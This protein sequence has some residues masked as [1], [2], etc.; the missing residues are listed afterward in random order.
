MPPPSKIDLLPP[1]VRAELDRRLIAHAFGNSVGL[2]EWLAEKGYEIGK[3]AV[4]LCGQAVL[5]SCHYDVLDW[6]EPD[7]IFDTASGRFERAE[8]GSRLRR[9]PNITLELWETDR[10][11]WPAFEPHHYLKLPPMIAATYYVAVAGGERVAHVAVTTCAGLR[12]ARA[13]RLVVMPEWQGVGIGTRILAEV[14]ER[15]RRGNNRYGIRVPTLFNTSHPGLCASLRKDTRWT[16]ISGSLIGNNR[17]RS[18]ASLVRSAERGKMATS[19]AGF[20]GH[21]R[22]VQGFR[23]LGPGGR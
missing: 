18:R 2:S 11:E 13:A 9:R 3:S 15:W 12:E 21:W 23:C 6:I 20:G 4:G 10:G 17:E 16:Q 8:A 7:W 22:A 5:V 19:G 14:C 1:E